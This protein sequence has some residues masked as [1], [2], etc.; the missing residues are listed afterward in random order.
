MFRNSILMIIFI[1]LHIGCSDSGKSPKLQGK[2][3]AKAALDLEGG[4]QGDA[5]KSGNSEELKGADGTAGTLIK[6]DSK[7]G[8]ELYGK[9]SSGFCD[10]RVFSTSLGRGYPISADEPGLKAMQ[11]IDNLEINGFFG[12]RSMTKLKTSM[13]NMINHKRCNNQKG[14]E[15][16]MKEFL[17]QAE[18]LKVEDGMGLCNFVGVIAMTP[19]SSVDH[20]PRVTRRNMRIAGK[21]IS[22]IGSVVGGV[23]GGIA[24]AAAATVGGATNAAVTGVNGIMQTA[25]GAANLGAAGPENTTNAQG[26]TKSQMISNVM[27]FVSGVDF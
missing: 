19:E 14:F 23:T 18:R 27:Q 7:E 15:R 21:V 1:A 20:D 12:G 5:V 11:V 17:R 16:N 3:K 10:F 9:L 8:L 2:S 6:E 25:S 13:V 4:D 22:G 24:G 26:I